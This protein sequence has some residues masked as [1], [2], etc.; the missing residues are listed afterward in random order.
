MFNGTQYD[1]ARFSG[2]SM[3]SPC[4]AGIAA[5]LLDANPLLT[6]AQ[7]KEILMT[8]ARTDDF[9]GPI[10]A[11][12]DVR[13]GM[14]KVDAYAAIQRALQTEGLSAQEV[15]SDNVSIYP[16]PASREIFVRIPYNE[17]PKS[18]TI[19]AMHGQQFTLPLINGRV[20][21]SSLA[22]GVYMLRAQK[23]VDI[24]QGRIVVQ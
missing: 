12:G 6:A 13:W 11:P 10:N 21:I 1:F 22:S 4:V 8:T 16:N 5:L 23:G 3:S 14:G 17:Q 18:V 20:D 19:F 2:T 24:Y 7:V 15:E 9:T